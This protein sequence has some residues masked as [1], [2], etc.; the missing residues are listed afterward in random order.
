MLYRAIV[1][2]MF[3]FAA[4]ILLGSYPGTLLKDPALVSET[5]HDAQMIEL[6]Q[7]AH[8]AMV[9]LQSRQQAFSCASVSAD[10]QRA[11]DDTRSKS[12]AS[13]KVD[14]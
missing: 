8:E 9:R 14:F 12:L 4:G 13:A 7:R 3:A 5:D 10:N 1:V 6:R 11:C 2:L